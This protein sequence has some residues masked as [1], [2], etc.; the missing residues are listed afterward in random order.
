M[1]EI[2]TSYRD[3]DDGKSAAI[4][5]A[6]YNSLLAQAL[7][8]Q[9][10]ND[11]ERKLLDDYINIIKEIVACYAEINEFICRINRS[12]NSHDSAMNANLRELCR[13]K[14]TL[15]CRLEQDLSLL[16]SRLLKRILERNSDK[17]KREKRRN[18]CFFKKK[19]K[20]EESN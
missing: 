17:P 20:K 15:V 7:S 13:K 3:A 1:K 4:E 14:E 19:I 9:P 6:K 10:K 16:N 18:F 5:E 2:Y 11:T 8:A 12:N